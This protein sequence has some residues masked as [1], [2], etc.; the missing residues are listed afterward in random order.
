M[1]AHQA[2]ATMHCAAHP[3][4]ARGPAGGLLSPAAYC[5]VVAVAYSSAAT[6]PGWHLRRVERAADAPGAVHLYAPY[7]RHT[8]HHDM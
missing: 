7:S 4:G 6:L 5:R 1:M 3:R 8:T 2:D